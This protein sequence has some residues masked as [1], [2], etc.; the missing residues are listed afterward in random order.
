VPASAVPVVR[1]A[2]ALPGLDQP[3]F[4]LPVALAA[5]G[6]LLGALLWGGVARVTGCEIGYVAWALGGLTGGGAVLAGGRGTAVAAAAAVL[7]LAGIAGGKLFGAHLV[8]EHQLGAL[9]PL[10]DRGAFE[11]MREA[12]QSA[13]DQ[14]AAPGAET[15]LAAVESAELASGGEGWD[16]D[17]DADVPLTPEEQQQLAAA[18]AVAAAAHEQQMRLL[19]DPAYTFEQWRAA[20]RAAVREQVPVVELVRATLGPFDLLFVLLGVGTAFGLVRRARG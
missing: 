7:A 8:V 3:P 18:C 16:D 9:D 12:A 17:D 15:A 19:R 20:Q 4:L 11:R 5:V 6:A 13:G 2:L 1:G 14:P 10:L